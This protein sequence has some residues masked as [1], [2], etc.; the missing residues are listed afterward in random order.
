MQTS[1]GF[2][3]GYVAFELFHRAPSELNHL[4]EQDWALATQ[5]VLE[6]GQRIKQESQ[7]NVNE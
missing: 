4:Y 7:K 2:L 5:Y 1:S 6:K 3:R